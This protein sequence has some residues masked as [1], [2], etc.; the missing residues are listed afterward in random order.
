MQKM[1]KAIVIIAIILFFV[2]MLGLLA[3]AS[4]E[5]YEVHEEDFVQPTY[6]EVE[7]T[8]YCDGE[9]CCRGE[10]PR[11]GICAGKPEWYGKV[12]ALY[13]NNNGIPGEFIGYFECLDTG[14]QP[15]KN[16]KVIDI[17]NPSREQCMEFGRQK[18]I[19]IIIEGEG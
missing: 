6:F 13:K 16:G 8:A 12:I 17:Y 3:T 19:A 5:D 2:S 14:G 15:I 10:I 18:V 9:V 1:I 7:A 11:M 4:Q